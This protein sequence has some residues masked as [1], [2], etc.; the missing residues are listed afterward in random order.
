MLPLLVFGLLASS[1]VFNINHSEYF[2]NSKSYDFGND[3]YFFHYL[4]MVDTFY[5]LGERYIEVDLQKQLAY[6][7][8]P[9]SVDTIK[10]SSGN[11]YL[12]KGIETPP[13]FFVVQNKAP[14]Q[15]SRQFENTEMINWVGFNGNIG[16]HALKKT[17]YYAHLGRRPS[18]HGCV[19]VSNEDGSKLF[20]FVRI[21]T[22]VIVYKK[23][24]IRKVAFIKLSEINFDT[25]LVISEI[26]P[27]Y[28]RYFNKRINLLLDGKLIA[29]NSPRIVL[30]PLVKIKSFASIRVDT[31]EVSV[32]PQK[33]SLFLIKKQN[34]VLL[35]TDYKPKVI[36]WDTCAMN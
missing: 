24:P 33:T 29:R 10:I 23:K 2:T 14:I 25:D 26:N 17:G 36:Y 34:P 35:S 19:R 4:P 22:P 30:N 8:T 32:P 1:F 27:S 7:I 6:I 28:V 16:F 20:Q 15:I 13:G 11:P 5:Y 21:G 12:H 9:Q 31:E 3:A 18:S